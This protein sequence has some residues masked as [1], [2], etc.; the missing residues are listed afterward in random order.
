MMRRGHK[1][2]T[3]VFV[4][5]SWSAVNDGAMGGDKTGGLKSGKY[6]V[7]VRL[8]LPHIQDTNATKTV[9]V[10][11]SDKATDRLTGLKVL[12][13]NN[14]L[15]NCPVSGIASGPDYIHFLIACPGANAANGLAKYQLSSTHF[16]GRITMNMGGKNM[17]MTETQ[18]G[19]RVGE[20]S[21]G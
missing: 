20:C 8:E 11:V 13:E 7:T 10:C 17:T 6:E 5:L 15:A 1:L 2:A 21:G 3:A 4:L 18:E 16:S 14:P 19:K 9:S 12:S